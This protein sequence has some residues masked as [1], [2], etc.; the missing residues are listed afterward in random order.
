[1]FEGLALGSRIATLSFHSKDFRPYLMALLYALTTPLGIA[2]GLGVRASYDPNSQRAL[3]SSGVFDSV[4]A[5]LLIYTAMVEL[6]AHDFIH[7]EMRTAKVSHVLIA[8]GSM[9]LGAA[10]MGLLGRW[11]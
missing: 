4:S 3:I 2:I 5:G 1:M 10:M 8:I 9:I 11:A 6:L 7:G